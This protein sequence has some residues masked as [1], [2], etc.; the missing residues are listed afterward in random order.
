MVTEPQDIE[1]NFWF[2]HVQ[3]IK[4][5]IT[6]QENKL[7]QYENDEDI[8]YGYFLTR[9]IDRKYTT[10]DYNKIHTKFSDHSLT[11]K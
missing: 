5:F 6:L 7:I 3:I 2:K 8:L 1:F 9:L 4:N 10:E 11:W